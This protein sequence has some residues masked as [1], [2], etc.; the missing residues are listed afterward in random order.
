MK[1]VLSV[2]LMVTGLLVLLMIFPPTSE[3][4]NPLMLFFGRF[5]P[6]ILHIPIGA[7]MTLFVLE[8]IQWW[9]HSKEGLNR[10][11]EIVLWVCVLSAVPAVMAG[12]LLASGGGYSEELL[13]KHLWLGWTT[14]F[15]ATWLLVIRYWAR[16]FKRAIWIYRNLL[17]INTIVLSLAGHFGG[18]LTHGSDYLTKYMPEEIKSAFG[19]QDKGPVSMLAEIEK[20]KEAGEVVDASEAQLHFATEIQPLMSE[21]C[22]ECHG[23][24]KQKGNIRLDELHWD[25]VHGPDAEGWHTALDQINAGTMPP[26]GKAKPTDEERRLL[27]SWMTE[28]LEQAAI[29]KRGE[30]KDIMRRLTRDQYTNTLN[31]LLYTNVNFGTVLPEDGKSEMGFTN[32]AETL[33]TSRLH[34]EYYQKIARDALDRAIVNGEKPEPQRYKVNL[35]ENN[36]KGKPA[37]KF[38]GYQSVSLGTDDFEVLILDRKGKAKSGPEVKTLQ[39]KIGVDLRGS[40]KDRFSVFPE[41]LNLYS[42]LPHREKAPKSW[43]GPSPNMKMLIKDIYP[44]NAP[45]VLRV[46]ASKGKF[47]ATLKEG[48]IRLRNASPAISSTDAIVLTPA[49]FT[50]RKNMTIDE[51]GWMAP[52]D[53]TSDSIAVYP[54]KVKEKGLYQIDLVHPYAAQDAMPSYTLA[55]GKR[56]KKQERFNLDK[57]LASKPSLVHPVTLAYLNKKTYNIVLG[58]KFFIGMKKLIVTPIGEDNPIFADLKNEGGINAEKYGDSYPELRAYAG[59]RTDDGMDYDNFGETV[60]VDA[61]PGKPKTYEFKGHLD[62][63]PVPAPGDNQSGHLASTMVMGL[64]N[65]YLVKNSDEAGPPVLIHSMEIE[66]PYYEVWPPQSHTEI[67]FDSPNRGKAEKEELYTKQVVERFME[68]AFR[69][70]IQRDELNFYMDFWRQT[71]QGFDHYEESVKEVLVAILCSPNFL[72]LVN[73]DSEP[74]SEGQQKEFLLASRL[75]YFLWNAPPDDELRRLATEGRLSQSLDQQLERMIQDPRIFEMIESFAYEWLRIDRLEQMN[76]SI[77]DY[78]DFTRFVKEDMAQETYQ[79]IHEV[80]TKNL[81]IMNFIESDFAMLN[82]N[83]AEFYGIDGVEGGHFRP[84]KLEDGSYRGGLLTQGAFLNGH[85]DGVQAH[86]IKR[87]VWLKEKILGEKPPPAPPNVPELDPDTPGFE[88]MT[89]KE[90]LE[91]H[92]NKASCVDCHLLIDP[93]GVVFENFDAS[94]RFIQTAKGKEIDASS[95]LPDGTNIE[96]IDGIKDYIL[97]LRRDSFTEALVEHLYAYAL[98]RDVTFADEMEVKEIAKAVAEDGYSFQSVLRHIIQCE[99]FIGKKTFNERMASM[100]AGIQTTQIRNHHHE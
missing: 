32:N 20:A 64:W 78:P 99:S 92:R 27:V 5:H 6:I 21:Y 11:C 22:Y 23:P 40:D 15:M 4:E 53:L 19:I 38:G 89:L 62:N 91:L 54:L 2:A 41:G 90:Q 9:H 85:S 72:Y 39:S 45:F 74:A 26:K 84:V 34:I 52:K 10:A 68:R 33:Q 73:P 79:F 42:A 49:D 12:F 100:D 8:A 57:S 97:D 86:P 59:T 29:A 18:S 93:Y 28:S 47:T 17:I 14:T 43:Q 30:S 70:D 75:S 95:T 63:L 16:D 55:M 60:I 37:G 96:G 25:I 1:V 77:T 98:G 61:E 81:S 88:K 58:G 65:D 76:T 83:M 66:A 67:F 48:F 94:G 50:L 51:D 46:E 7:L 13:N 24:E 69:R 71:R 44:S 31:E 35:G 36:G 56:L 87:A 3:G 82:Q 80:L